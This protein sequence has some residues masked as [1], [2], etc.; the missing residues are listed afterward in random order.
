MPLSRPPRW[1]I[2]VLVGLALAPVARS[3][4]QAK[5]AAQPTPGRQPQFAGA[6]TCKGCH[7]EPRTY[8]D[9]QDLFTLKEYPTWK[10]DDQH[11]QAFEVL[12]DGLAKEMAER[13]KAAGHADYGKPPTEWKA[14]LTCHAIDTTLAEKDVSAKRFFADDGVSCE[15][16]HGWADRWYVLH[17]N[18]RVWRVRTA[19]EKEADGLYDM[20]DA[21]RRA[22]RCSACHVGNADEAKIITHEMY[23]AGHPPLPS[24]EPVTFSLLQPKHF[25]PPREAEFFKRPEGQ[26]DAWERYHYRPD[27]LPQT[28]QVA[29]GAA[30][31]FRAAVKLVAAEAGRRAATPGKVLDFASFDCAAC[32]HD[33]K[34]PGW[35][36][37]PAVAAAPGRP[38]LSRWPSVL[39]DVAI[40]HAG[41]ADAGSELAD[42]LNALHAA[43]TTGPF[44]DAQ[45][46]AAAATAL[47]GWA[48]KAVDRLQGHKYTEAEAERLLRDLAAKA[49]Q[50]GGPRPVHDYDSARQL[51]WA[52]KVVYA[53]VG[54]KVEAI[55]ASLA[56]LE[57]VLDLTFRRPDAYK[58]PIREQLEAWLLT[59]GSYDP[60]A[61]QTAF[62]RIAAALESRP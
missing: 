37:T 49:V 21:H 60:A 5:D 51:A 26:K 47:D 22:E 56:D 46:V 40:R 23:A 43:A 20:R 1:P 12:K 32:H 30:V 55:D 10:Q 58:K 44:G 6:E 48:G 36:Q 57:K 42:K 13:L 41:G 62:K 50:P 17:A 16:C 52:F 39:L 35:R 9:S 38:P 45:A 11:A 29:V 18:R 24:L 28:R 3:G 34:T 25:I 53:E 4:P 31:T 15:A 61:F 14:C 2:L 19:A 33:L 7:T 54:K 8:P 59:A 27:E